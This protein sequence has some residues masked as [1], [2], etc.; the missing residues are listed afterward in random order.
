M[1]AIARRALEGARAAVI[2]AFG[3]GAL[4]GLLTGVPLLVAAGAGAIVGMSLG[5]WIAIARA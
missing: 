3:L 2:P 1:I 5:A 4:A